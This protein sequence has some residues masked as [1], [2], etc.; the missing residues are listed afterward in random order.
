MPAGVKCKIMSLLSKALMIGLLTGILGIGL[1]PVAHDLE[2]GFGLDLL[3]RL[4]GTRN[5][6]SSAV[7]VTM[8]RVSANRLKLPPEPEEWPRSL[9][10]R[11]IDTLVQ[12]GAKVIAFDIFGR[13]SAILR[14]NPQGTQCRPM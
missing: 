7:V 9:H 4:R 10:A 1:F 5:P 2:E 6:P 14:C 12:G 8:D 3:F 13:G 11:L